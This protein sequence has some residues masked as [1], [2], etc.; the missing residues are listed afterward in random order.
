MKAAQLDSYSASPSVG[1]APVPEPGPD[2]VV[3]RVTAASLNPLDVKIQGGM[4]RD[5]FGVTFPYTV[6]TDVAGTVHQPGA[7]A[8]RWKAGQAVVARLDPVAGGAVAE[9]AVVPAGQ[10]VAAPAGVPLDELAGLPTAAGTAWQALFE[11][12][13]LQRGQTVLVHG[14][15]GAVGGF[16]VQLARHAGARVIATASGTGIDRARGFGADPVIDYKADDFAARV[17]GVDVVL[18]TVGGDTQTRSLGVLRPGGTLVSTV[19]PP[20]EAAAKAR[21]VTAKFMFHQSDAGRLAKVV[22]LLA[23]GT[24]RVTVDRRVSLANVGDAFERQASGARGKILIAV[25]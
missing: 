25:G 13:H 10:L 20:D 6:G 7:A 4:M 22:D 19:A 15:A 1:D 17:S 11:T 3:I 16:A 8:G 12:A 9:F 21:G 5:Y 24:L 2:Q 14:G 23:A 18:D